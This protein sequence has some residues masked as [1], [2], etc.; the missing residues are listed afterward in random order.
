[1]AKTLIKNYPEKFN[2]PEY[3]AV[4]SVMTELGVFNQKF[5]R[6]K[7]AGYVVRLLRRKKMA[8]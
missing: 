7:I 4:K 5:T 1:M 8:A 3:S 6:N 2:D